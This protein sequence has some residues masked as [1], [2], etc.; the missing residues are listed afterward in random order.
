MSPS[1]NRM[2]TPSYAA[3]GTYRSSTPVAQASRH[4]EDT[5]LHEVHRP[6]NG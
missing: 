2:P 5:G 3:V 6:W 4:V 1:I